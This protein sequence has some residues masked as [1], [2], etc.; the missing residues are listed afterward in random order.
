[1]DIALRVYIMRRKVLD[2]AGPTSEVRLG[3][4]LHTIWEQLMES[5]EKHDMI[6]FAF[7]NNKYC[8]WF[9]ES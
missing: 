3:K 5:V 2:E 7:W 8:W 4:S 9:Y 1:M 6:R